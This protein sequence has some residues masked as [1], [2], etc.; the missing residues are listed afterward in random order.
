[1][2]KLTSNFSRVYVWDIDKAL[3][4]RKMWQYNVAQWLRG[5]SQG[6]EMYFS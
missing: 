3:T 6:H 2:L 4:S 5:A 1:M